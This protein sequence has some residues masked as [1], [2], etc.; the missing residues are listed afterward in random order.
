MH[1][2]H[3]LIVLKMRSECLLILLPLWLIRKGL[4]TLED[5]LQGPI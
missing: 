4:N 3:F 2:R 1:S 5:I